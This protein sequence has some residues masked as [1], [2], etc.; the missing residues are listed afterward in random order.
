MNFKKLIF[1]L[2]INLVSPSIFIDVYGADDGNNSNK[3]LSDLAHGLAAR[4]EAFYSGDHTLKERM[5]TA[6]F[7]TEIKEKIDQS[8][9]S[10]QGL[11]SIV[12]SLIQNPNSDSAS[13]QAALMR[14]KEMI[15][16]IRA[17]HNSAIPHLT[18]QAIEKIALGPLKIEFGRGTTLSVL[19]MIND[20]HRVLTNKII[21]SEVAAKITKLNE[22]TEGT[23]LASLTENIRENILEILSALVLRIVDEID[24]FDIPNI[25][26]AVSL[27][28][29]EL[30]VA[31]GKDAAMAAKSTLEAI[32]II[33]LVSEI[34]E[35]ISDI[36]NPQ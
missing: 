9:S 26:S 7:L 11:E 33:S 22:I 10:E 21:T 8:L 2:T 35:L 14:L 19:E 36:P 27:K 24:G 32:S 30:E 13:D 16:E 1:I 28:T 12:D 4:T 18:I 29:S 20:K 5:A 31:L 17:G 6:I 23:C 34:K 3:N 15:T 25:A